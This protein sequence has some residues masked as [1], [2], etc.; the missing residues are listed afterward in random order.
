MLPAYHDTME[1]LPG[2]HPDPWDTSRQRYWDGR[3]WTSFTAVRSTPPAPPH[4]T[5]PLRD[6]VG[7]VVVLAASLIASRF[8]LAAIAPFGWPIAVYVTLLALVG[9]GPALLYVLVVAGHRGDGSFRA[10]T[11]L[12]ARRIDTAW[13]LVTWL[14]CVGAQIAAALVVTATRLPITSNTEGLDEIGADRAYVLSLLVVAV[15][16]A[17]LVEEIVFRGVVL[18]GLLSRYAP[19]AAITIQAIVFGIAHVDP[20]RGAGNIGLV[21]VLSSVGAVLGI[22]AYRLRRITPSIG[23]HAVLNAVAMTLAL[24]GVASE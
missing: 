9:Y 24:S 14:S 13:S 23:A 16:A 5:L 21:V 2:W 20:M 15:V 11:G 7:A 10:V 1:R 19:A 17:P 18:R 8:V 12:F 6:A 4:P 3:T 22:A